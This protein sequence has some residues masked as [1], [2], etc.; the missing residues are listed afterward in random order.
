VGL[1]LVVGMVV[2][3]TTRGVVHSHCEVPCGIYGDT[4][5]VD[6]LYE[7]CTTVEKAMQQAMELEKA[8]P[9]NFNQLV[10]WT[11][12]KEKHADEIQ[13]IVTQYFMTQR[14]KPKM[15]NEGKAYETYVAQLTTLHGMLIAA[16]KSKQTTDTANVAELRN[17]LKQFSKLYFNEEDLK[18][19]EAHHA[20]GK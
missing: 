4:M 1:A 19:I 6:M 7:H 12:N 9:V 13:H 2:F 8:D 18:H 11:V 10:R 17:I 5:R 15:A 3:F 16:M 14:V 20:E